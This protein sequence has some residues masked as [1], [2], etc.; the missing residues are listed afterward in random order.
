METIYTSREEL[1]Y[2][3]EQLYEA[4]EANGAWIAI[5]PDRGTINVH[6]QGDSTS[7]IQVVDIADEADLADLI[8]GKEDK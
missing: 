1:K 5:T 2:T 3:L 4:C 6:K 8:F 7:Y